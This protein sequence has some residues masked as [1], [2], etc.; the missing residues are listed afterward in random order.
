M[1]VFRK[2]AKPVWVPFLVFSF[3]SLVLHA[4]PRTRSL[5]ALA[6]G[7]L[8][9]GHSPSEQYLPDSEQDRAQTQRVR[10]DED[11]I[12]RACLLGLVGN[13]VG[14]CL[15]AGLG[16][17]LIGD[18]N[19]GESS[20]SEGLLLA[21]AAAGSVCG[22][23]LGVYLGGNSRQARGKLDSTMLG[24]FLGGVAAAAITLAAGKVFDRPH[25]FLLSFAVLPPLGSIL[26]LNSSLRSRSTYEG[27][28]LFNLSGRRLGLGIPDIQVRPLWAP[29]FQAKPEL[30]FNVRVLSVEL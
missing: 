15:F 26:L 1:N 10:M 17:N 21:A 22:S 29:G 4:D 8:P 6:P 14:S 18:K 9:A 28:A 3:I 2:K 13:V 12:V 7:P 25:I 11:R 23:A 16:Y 24:S 5:F 30:Q 27:N 20:S 19:M